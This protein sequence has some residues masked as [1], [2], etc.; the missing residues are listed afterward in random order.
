MTGTD[1]YKQALSFLD[2]IDEDGNVNT[3]TGYEGKAPFI[4]DAIQRDVEHLAGV[5]VLK[6][7]A[8]LTDT[9]YVSD[10]YALRVMPYGVA[11]EFALQDKMEDEYQKN[12]SEY[13]KRL[14]SVR[15]EKVTKKDPYNL[16]AGMQ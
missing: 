9:L 16:L 4:I 3:D 2:E 1:V 8:V 6:P 7:V 5:N 10:D 12:Y 13:Q 15:P 11:A 14:R